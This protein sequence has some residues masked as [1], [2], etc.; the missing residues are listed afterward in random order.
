MKTLLDKLKGQEK[1]SMAVSGLKGSSRALLATRLAHKLQRPVVLITASEEQASALFQDMQLLSNLPLLHYPG[2]D[3]PPYTP[4]SPDPTTVASRLSTLYRLLNINEPYILVVPAE[5]L[6]RRILPKETLSNLAELVIRGEDTDQ[7]EL[8]R[9]LLSAG[10]EKVSLVQN[11][12]EISLRGGILDVFPPHPG[13]IQAGNE[14]AT[15]ISENFPIR[16][17]FFG[18][19]VESIRF[20][21][22]ISQRSLQE[23]EEFTVLPVSDIL[24]CN[25]SDE[26]SPATEALRASRELGWDPDETDFLVDQLNMEARFPGIEFFLP[27][28]H[29]T[30]ASPLE[31]VQ[32]NALLLITDPVEINSTIEL[33]WERIT[34]NHQE[35]IAARQPSLIPPSVFLQI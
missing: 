32:E 30:P 16:L 31:Y 14:K 28:F 5:A 8:V 7:A 13:E 23:L 3:I 12:G 15:Y 18:D 1:K 6:L 26:T 22:P 19:T 17:D 35:S 4:L 27:L 10:Y 21:D 24:Y 20:F 33:T 2:F 9:R 25:Q 11:S 29:E 34:A